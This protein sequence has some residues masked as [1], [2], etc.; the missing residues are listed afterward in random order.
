VTPATSGQLQSVA[1]GL[2]VQI[3]RQR[4]QVTAR[5]RINAAFTGTPEVNDY[6]AVAGS[7]WTLD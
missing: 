7:S 2:Q 6:G 5:L 1:G 4:N 3:S